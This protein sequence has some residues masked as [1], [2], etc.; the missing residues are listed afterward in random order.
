MPWDVILVDAPLGYPSLGPGRHQSLYMT[1]LLAQATLRNQR[2]EPTVVHVFVGD[3]EAPGRA[4][5]LAK[6]VC[7]C[8]SDQPET[9]SMPMNKRTLSWIPT[10]QC[11]PAVLLLGQHR[12]PRTSTSLL[13][14]GLRNIHSNCHRL[15]GPSR[16][17]DL[18][19]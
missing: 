1:N 4:Q 3:Y 11:A 2:I 9:K 12:R 19:P 16:S 5:I 15:F 18:S 10:A 7:R 6:R 14:V 13:R 8:A 17:L